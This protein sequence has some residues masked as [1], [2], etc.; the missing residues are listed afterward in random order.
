M[1]VSDDGPGLPDIA[2][3]HLFQAFVGSASKGGSGLGLTTA[4]DLMRAHQGEL[5]LYRSSEQGTV[6][7]LELPIV[8][9]AAVKQGATG[10]NI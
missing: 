4:R 2:L 1:T 7:R 10:I 3:K 6:F 5:S 8:G 9:G